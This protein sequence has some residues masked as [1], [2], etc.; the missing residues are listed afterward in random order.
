M[1]KFYAI[2][3]IFPGSSEVKASA[4]NAGDLGSISGLGS[5]PGAGNG[6]PLKY[7]CLE[8]SMDGGD[9][10]ATVHGI[11][12]SQTCEQLHWFTGQTNSQKNYASQNLILT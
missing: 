10:Q 9:W 2:Y 1:V 7:S 3:N 11:A 5:S 6:N 12:K 8:N 4:G